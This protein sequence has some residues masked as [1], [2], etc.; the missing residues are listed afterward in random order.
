MRYI[1]IDLEMH[2][3]PEEYQFE[4]NICKNETI[5]IGAVMLND[6]FAETGEFQSLV[7]PEYCREIYPRYERLTGLNYEKLQGE[8]LF[9]EVFHRFCTWCR[10]GGD[11]FQVMAWSDSDFWQLIHEIC[12]KRVDLSDVEKEMM[13]SWRDFQKEFGRIIRKKEQISLDRALYYADLSF[14]GKRH[15]ALWD[16]RNTANLFRK[17]RK[18]KNREKIAEKA[19]TMLVKDP[20]TVTLGDLFPFDAA[21]CQ[22]KMVGKK[23]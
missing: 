16:A 11:A 3:L 15:S 10:E 19:K 9:A 5:E 8:E 18:Q 7:R 12:L 23:Q 2:P 1:V 20:L 4:K 6:S 22:Q 13:I 21:V 17:T 14:C